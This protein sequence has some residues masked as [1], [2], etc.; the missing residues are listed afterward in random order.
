MIAL[1]SPGEDLMVVAER[2]GVRTIAVLMERHMSLTKD[3][4]LFSLI[5]VFRK[6]KLGMVHNMIPKAGGGCMIAAWQT[7]VPVRVHTSLGLYFQQLG[8]N[9]AY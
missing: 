5:R 4:S 9:G 6:E 1:S 8:K 3:L 7:R 2:E